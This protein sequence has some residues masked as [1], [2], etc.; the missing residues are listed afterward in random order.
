[1]LL[2]I[3]AASGCTT[4]VLDTADIQEIDGGRIVMSQSG[5]GT[6]RVEDA[7]IRTFDGRVLDIDPA[8]VGPVLG[9]VRRE[10]GF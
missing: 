4:H 7:R 3:P 10:R 5:D 8:W 1:M 6:G 2:Q 9:Q